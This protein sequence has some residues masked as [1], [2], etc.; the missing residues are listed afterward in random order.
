MDRY[1][2][3]SLLAGFSLSVVLGAVLYIYLTVG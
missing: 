2:I 3:P 1:D